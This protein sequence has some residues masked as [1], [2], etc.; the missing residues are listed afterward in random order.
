MLPFGTGNDGPQ[1]FGWGAKPNKEWTTDLELLMRD[2]IDSS[3]AAL[4]LWRGTVDGDVYD[5]VGNKL[6]PFF[7]M[8]YYYNMGADAKVGHTVEANR[9]RYRVCNLI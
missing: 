6:D 5:A 1:F 9:T 7:S 2:H 3:P 8:C 4:T